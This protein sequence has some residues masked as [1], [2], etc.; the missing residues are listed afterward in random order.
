MK[1]LEELCKNDIKYVELKDICEIGT[2]SSNAREAVEDGIYPFYIRSKEV[3]RINKYEYDEKA[4]IIPGEGGI[5]DI[6]HY[7]EGKYSLHQRAYRIAV[8]DEKIY[9]KFVY[10]YLKNFFKVWIISKAVSGT[11]ISIR[12]PMIEEFK[13]PVINLDIQQKIANILDNYTKVNDELIDNLNKEYSLRRKQYEYYRDEILIFGDEVLKVRLKEVVN[14]SI[15]TKPDEILEYGDYKYINAGTTNSGYT[16]KFNT[17]AD[18]VTT[19][20]RGQGGIGFIGY[21]KERFWCGPLSYK[22]KEKNFEKLN[23][24]YIY[25]I[26]TSMKNDI[27][28]L[29]KVGSIPAIN[30]GDLLELIIPLPPLEKQREI[31]NILDKYESMNNGVRKNILSE[32]EM[33]EKQYLYYM[34][35]LLAL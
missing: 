15:G 10:Y 13:I 16:N 29:K 4:I 30:S 21:Q 12:K 19:P 28:N 22:I 20:S 23:T 27:L 25:Y 31:V 32:I 18:Y 6:F 14:I 11:V 3:K 8:K 1:F 5:G 26:L 24:K 9:P 17:E 34:N 2:G 33:R 35:K 7:V